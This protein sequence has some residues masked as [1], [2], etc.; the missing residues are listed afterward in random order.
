MLSLG[1]MINLPLA[2]DSSMPALATN[3]PSLSVANTYLVRMA[4]SLSARIN[5][6]FAA[7]PS[8]LAVLF[9]ARA[10][11]LEVTT[12]IDLSGSFGTYLVIKRTRFSP[13][14]KILVLMAFTIMLLKFLLNYAIIIYRNNPKRKQ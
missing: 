7:R 11:I 2:F 6:S 12:K 13:S 9:S 10:T 8:Y 1:S 4:H 3:A 14:K 5:F